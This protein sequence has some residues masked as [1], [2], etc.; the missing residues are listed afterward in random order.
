MKTTII[1]VL[2]LINIWFAKTIIQLEK[3]HYSV[4][5]GMCGDF[6]GE[7][8]RTKWL[9]CNEVKETR[10]NKLWHLFYA[11]SRAEFDSYVV[12]KSGELLKN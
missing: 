9:A 5:I 4:H 7:V 2:V 8:E 12:G 11:T 3:F 6:K 1:I 10:T